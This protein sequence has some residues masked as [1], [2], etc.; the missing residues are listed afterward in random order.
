MA[1]VLF[2]FL[3]WFIGGSSSNGPKVLNFLVRSPWMTI[4]VV[5]QV[6]DAGNISFA[7]RI[8]SLGHNDFFDHN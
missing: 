3:K 5:G 7:F 6:R 1:G 8:R 4:D 2:P